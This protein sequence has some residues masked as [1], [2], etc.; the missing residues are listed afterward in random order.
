MHH[1]IRFGFSSNF[2]NRYEMKCDAMCS[3]KCVVILVQIHGC[4]LHGVEVRDALLYC[5]ILICLQG[6]KKVLIVLG[7]KRKN[8]L[9]PVG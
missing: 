3:F 2:E 1:N 6:I 8:K 4:H 9:S 5:H 7:I